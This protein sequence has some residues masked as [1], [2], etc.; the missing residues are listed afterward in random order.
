MSVLEGASNK[1]RTWPENVNL[2]CSTLREVSDQLSALQ[3][4]A[5]MEV[6]RNI[7]YQDS[8]QFLMILFEAIEGA[9]VEQYQQMLDEV[10]YFN[11]VLMP[12]EKT[13]LDIIV[14]R[15]IQVVKDEKESAEK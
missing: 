9:P 10:I 7:C 2:L 14:R 1:P 5:Q 15:A 12:E 3:R 4:S 11:F 6:W 8:L 13:H